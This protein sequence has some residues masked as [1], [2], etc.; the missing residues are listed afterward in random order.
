MNP[1]MEFSGAYEPV[2]YWCI[3]GKKGFRFGVSER[4][5]WLTRVL[6]R[7]LLEWQWRDAQ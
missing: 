1:L 4:P 3:G 7:A 5:R 2:G 6:M